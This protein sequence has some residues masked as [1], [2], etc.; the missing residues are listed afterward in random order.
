MKAISIRVEGSTGA[1]VIDVVQDCIVL[2]SQLNCGVWV[3]INE[4]DVL[5]GPLDDCGR[6]ARNHAEAVRHKLSVAS[7][8]GPHPVG[9]DQ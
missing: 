2:A 4:I 8:A 3:N 1:K 7:A 9:G 6:V 5:V